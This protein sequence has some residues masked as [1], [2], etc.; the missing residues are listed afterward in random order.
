MRKGLSEAQVEAA[1][2]DLDRADLPAKT[3]AALRLATGRAESKVLERFYCTSSV[4]RKREDACRNHQQN[5]SSSLD[6][7][8]RG[9]TGVVRYSEPEWESGQL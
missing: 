9:G 1:L 7:V 8:L 4:Q 3:I 2:G 6:P 5:R